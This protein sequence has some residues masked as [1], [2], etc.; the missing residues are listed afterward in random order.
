MSTPDALVAQYL[1]QLRGALATAGVPDARRMEIVDEVVA[2]L[3]EARAT[4]DASDEAALRTVLERLG[5]PEEIAA[6]AADS[7]GPTASTN[8]TGT[9]NGARTGRRRR[10]V[11]EAVGALAALGA[12]LGLSVSLATGPADVRG[13]V[14]AVGRGQ[15]R[16]TLVRPNQVLAPRTLTPA[17]FRVGP[18]RVAVRT[19]PGGAVRSITLLNPATGRIVASSVC[20]PF[21]VPGA[22][23]HGSTFW[24]ILPGRGIV[25]VP[26]PGQVVVVPATG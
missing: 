17:Q 6:E 13:I 23:V 12:I 10:S 16:V 3:R 5:S 7:A 26:G 25:G 4:L 24:Q 20:P 22:T 9:A 11:L 18:G 19:S 21:A 2:H 14:T 8:G 15:C 1:E